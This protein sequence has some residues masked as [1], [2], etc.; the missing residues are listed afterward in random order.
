VKSWPQKDQLW[1]IM[2]DGNVAVFHV[3]L[4]LAEKLFL[5]I[6]FVCLLACTSR[7]MLR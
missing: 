1:S 4:Q 7:E 5:V 6:A 3:F 2:I